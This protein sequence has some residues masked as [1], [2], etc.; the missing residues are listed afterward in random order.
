[1]L[2]G[3]PHSSIRIATPTRTVVLVVG[4]PMYLVGTTTSTQSNTRI[5]A[6]PLV[7]MLVQLYLQYPR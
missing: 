6:A 7:S 5:P 2:K 1:M 4:I 3:I